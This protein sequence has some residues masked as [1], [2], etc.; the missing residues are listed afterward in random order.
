MINRKIIVP[1][2]HQTLQLHHLAISHPIKPKNLNHTFYQLTVVCSTCMYIKA[3][4]YLAMPR[5][6]LSMHHWQA[7]LHATQLKKVHLAFSPR[8]I[9]T[10]HVFPHI[11]HFQWS[12]HFSVQV[13]C[14]SMAENSIIY[15]CM[16]IQKMA[17]Y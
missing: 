9:L 15:A 4:Q 7:W 11:L 5:M 16:Y 8:P 12:K 13:V 2:L 6:S 14:I 3:S 1:C 17:K 10:H